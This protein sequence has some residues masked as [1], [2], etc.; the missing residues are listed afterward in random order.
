MV[1]ESLAYNVVESVLGTWVED[2]DKSKLKVSAHER[3][4]TLQMHTQLHAHMRS[5]TGGC[6]VWPRDSVL[7]QAEK[8]GPTCLRPAHQ[9]EDG[10]PGQGVH[11]PLSRT[12]QR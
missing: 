1:F 6:L 4:S 3:A 12:D 9:R 5:H 7:A 8:G 11:A 2:L 10:A